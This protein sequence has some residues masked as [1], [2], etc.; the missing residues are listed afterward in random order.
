MTAVRTVWT[1]SATNLWT[2]SIVF[3]VSATSSAMST[4][5]AEKSTAF[6]TGGSITGMARVVPSP[7]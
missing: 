3:P 7:V 5:F 2:S 6:G 1:C 4:F